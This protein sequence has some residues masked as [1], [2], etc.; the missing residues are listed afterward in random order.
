M[1]D[2]WRCAARWPDSIFEPAANI[3]IDADAVSA[4][5]LDDIRAGGQMSLDRRQLSLTSLVVE[6]PDGRLEL[7]GTVAASGAD[8]SG[9]FDLRIDHSTFRIDA[10]AR[11]AA[12]RTR[13]GKRLVDGSPAQPHVRAGHGEE[14]LANGLEFQSLSGA[15]ELSGDLLHVRDLQLS[16]AGGQ[17]LVN[18]AYD[19]RST[20]VSATV[21]GRG[22]HLALDCLSNDAERAGD[23]A[24]ELENVVID[25]RLAGPARRLSGEVSLSA[26]A[27]RVSGRDGGAVVV[28][29]HVEQGRAQL[30]LF[31]VRLAATAAASVS[32][33]SPWPYTATVTLKGASLG[34]SCGAHRRQ[35]EDSRGLQRNH[36]WIFRGARRFAT[37]LHC[38]GDDERRRAGG[39][40]A[41]RPLALVKPVRLSYD[42]RVPPSS[43][44]TSTSAACR[45]AGPERGP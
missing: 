31:S 20:D 27:L 11:M 9:E 25:A 3:A 24:A 4:G 36:H 10:P 44:F 19:V 22:L 43:R 37:S 8:S 41:G 39:G 29:G 40:G 38:D 16:Q 1:P 12:D 30:N 14:L 34:H 28:R 42:G 21:A 26:D 2:A 45:H 33:E 5:G 18:G 35:H 15:V 32:L 7:R 6:S 13:A 17:L 23:R